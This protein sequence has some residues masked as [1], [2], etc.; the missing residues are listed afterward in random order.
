MADPPSRRRPIIRD[1]ALREPSRENRDSKEEETVRHIER[2]TARVAAMEDQ[3]M[4]AN[5]AIAHL[6][7]LQSNPPMAPA[8]ETPP[9]PRLRAQSWEPQSQLLRS[10]RFELSPQ[11]LR[12]PPAV[13]P[14]PASLEVNSVAQPVALRAL[15]PTP[16]ALHCDILRF[17]DAND[18]FM[19]AQA[20]AREAVFAGL[21]ALAR[22]RDTRS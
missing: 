6:A 16:S 4:V 17:V 14:A 22:P 20:P 5:A 18:A 13:E 21:R 11:P 10:P 15:P 3:L 8:T 2:L 7:Q 12:L 19:R 1:Y 9:Q